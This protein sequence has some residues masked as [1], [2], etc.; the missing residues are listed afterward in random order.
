MLIST[1]TIYPERF[2]DGVFAADPFAASL[3]VFDYFKLG[4]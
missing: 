4:D 1:A 2:K 3:A